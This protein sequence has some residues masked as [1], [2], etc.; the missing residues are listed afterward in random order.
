M[1][2]LSPTEPPLS[3]AVRNRRRREFCHRFQREQPAGVHDAVKR[4]KGEAPM[5]PVPLDGVRRILG[6]GGDWWFRTHE[7]LGL[8][9]AIYVGSLFERH[10]LLDNEWVVGRTEQAPWALISEPYRSAD[11]V[12]KLRVELE[13]VG[14]ELIEYPTEQA[15]HHPGHTLML[16]ANIVDGRR[17]AAA[18][19][20][21][22]VDSCEV[23][24]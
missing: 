1:P 10:G 24:R 20:R 2:E 22:I 7:P 6:L 9:G 18:V 16:C 13:A 21:L 5:P 14:V 19:A 17:L 23:P 12:P 15:T 4:Y 11:N 8:L 3:T